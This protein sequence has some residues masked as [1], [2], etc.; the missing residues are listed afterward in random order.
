MIFE[1]ESL[2]FQGFLGAFGLPQSTKTKKKRSEGK[3]KNLHVILSFGFYITNRN[4]NNQVSNLPV[5]RGWLGHES[6]IYLY[7]SGM[8][9]KPKQLLSSSSHLDAHQKQTNNPTP[10]SPTQSHSTSPFSPKQLLC[11]SRRLQRREEL[12]WTAEAAPRQ[13][14]AAEP[15]GRGV[16]PR[17]IRFFFFSLRKSLLLVVNSRFS[18]KTRNIGAAEML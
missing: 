3:A 8:S 5:L 1:D 17:W 10:T 2:W 9:F 14:G 15:Q 16:Q 18:F 4:K 11:C 13:R 6:I 12:R 7:Y